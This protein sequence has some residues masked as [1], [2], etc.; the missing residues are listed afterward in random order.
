M[1][2]ALAA[3][4]LLLAAAAGAQREQD[5]YAF[6]A[7]NIRGKLVSL[8]K[9]RGSVSV[10][11][12][13]ASGGA[14]WGRRRP[15]SVPRGVAPRG[16]GLPRVP[17]A[18]PPPC[19]AARVSSAATWQ[20]PA[21]S[22]IRTARGAGS[23]FPEADFGLGVRTPPAPLQLSLGHARVEEVTPAPHGLCL[24]VPSSNWEG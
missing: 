20:G 23:G 4:W 19:S 9:Y 18:S 13:G 8:E 10:R 2:A 5:F 17:P 21:P 7:V 12:P 6:Q 24:R 3:A 15:A 14:G 22:E 11:P 16:L 1:V